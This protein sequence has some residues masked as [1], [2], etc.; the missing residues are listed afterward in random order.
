[1]E[2]NTLVALQTALSTT[3]RRPRTMNN[4]EVDKEHGEGWEGMGGGMD[5]TQKL[6]RED[7]QEAQ[8]RSAVQSRSFTACSNDFSSA[9]FHCIAAGA[10]GAAPGG[11][12]AAP[13]RGPQCGAAQWR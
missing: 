12:G 13:A 10:S 3:A 1:M 8:R 9:H 6:K 4:T 5:G 11:P 7:L 2:Q